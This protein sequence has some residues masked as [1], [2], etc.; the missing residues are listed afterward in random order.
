[1]VSGPEDAEIMSHFEGALRNFLTHYDELAAAKDD[2]G[3]TAEFIVS[4]HAV[5]TGLG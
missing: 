2:G 1:M 3:F 4:H 5:A